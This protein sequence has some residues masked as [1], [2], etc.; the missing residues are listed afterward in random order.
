MNWGWLKTVARVGLNVA[1]TMNPVVGAVLNA[2][3]V[4]EAQPSTKK[5]AQKEDAAVA[6]VPSILALTGLD[7]R[8]DA[9]GVQDAVRK[10]LQTYVAVQDAKSAV[11]LAVTQFEAAR[12]ALEAVVEDAK[13]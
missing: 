11:E 4:V 5:G 13:S 9:P 8:L 1:G 7:T 10:V 3:N 2:A 6:L 12:A